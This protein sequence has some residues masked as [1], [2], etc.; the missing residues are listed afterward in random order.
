[1]R[2]K[3]QKQIE[4]KRSSFSLL[5]AIALSMAMLATSLQGNTG[6]ANN[7][8]AKTLWFPA[9]FFFINNIKSTNRIFRDI[10]DTSKEISIQTALFLGHK[11]MVPMASRYLQG[12]PLDDEVKTRVLDAMERDSFR[13]NVVPFLYQIATLY[14]PDQVANIYPPAQKRLVGTFDEAIRQHYYSPNS[15]SG[16]IPG[17]EHELFQFIPQQSEVEAKAEGEAESDQGLPSLDMMASNIITLYDA[18]YLQGDQGNTKEGAPEITPQMIER[19]QKVIAD[20]LQMLS[21]TL[22]SNPHLKAGIEDIVNNHHRMETFIIALVDFLTGTI[23]Q[24]YQTYLEGASR[25]LAMEQQATKLFEQAANKEE[26]LEQI[27]NFTHWILQK[28]KYAVH[29]VIDGLQG[30]LVE[31][32]ASPT[33]WENPFL[34]QIAR[35]DREKERYRPMQEQ[36]EDIALPVDNSFLHHLVTERERPEHYLPWLQQLYRKHKNSIARNGISTTPTVSVRNIPIALT[37]TAVANP[38]GGGTGLPSFHYVDRKQEDGMGER[39]FYFYGNDAIYLPRIAAAHGAKTPH[40][41]MNQLGLFSLNCN[42]NYSEGAIASVD[43]LVNLYA[44]EEARDFGEVIC[45]AELKKRAAVQARIDRLA[46]SLQRDIERIR[47]SFWPWASFQLARYVLKS[48]MKKIAELYYQGLPDYLVYYNPWPDHFAHYYGPFGNAIIS[49]T[50]ELARMDY[51]LQQMEGAYR[52]SGHYRRTLFAMAGDHG[53]AE[54]YYT[55]N[56]ELTVLK[57]SGYDFK[58]IKISSDEGEAPKMHHP[59]NPPTMRDYDVVVAS[60]AGG[61]YMMDFFH[62]DSDGWQEQPTIKD[63]RQHQLL[64]GEQVDI[65]GLTLDQ[66]PETL[67]YLVVRNGPCSPSSTDIMAMAPNGKSAHI[68]RKGERIYYHSKEDLL[69]VRTPSRYAHP[70]G[71]SQRMHYEQ[72]QRQCMDQANPQ[73]SQTWCHETQWRELASYTNNPDSV[74]QLAHLYD[75]PKAGTI[76][77]FPGH[78]IGYNTKVP[79]RHAGEH[80]HEKDSFIGI[81]GGPLENPGPPAGPNP[82]STQRL[83]TAVV[84]QVLPTLYQYIT[85]IKMEKGHDGL[86]FDPIDLDTPNREREVG[87]TTPQ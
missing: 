70:L 41:R 38:E 63:L 84:G 83:Q 31:A 43:G 64:S 74:G 61:N 72:L 87:T 1:M 60:T 16:D 24:Q 29:I 62:H 78:G 82:T 8:K 23:N 76:N 73:D 12:L 6:E 79:G 19:V 48:D 11:I 20:T 75:S 56:P 28:R 85:G 52:D 13:H 15:P 81:W 18:I 46:R 55:L 27:G 66:L 45:I 36:V 37:G 5:A 7:P 65:I 33:P 67:K 68:L 53:L 59:Y 86:S 26:V 22:E 9:P 40:K 58:T 57:Q 71:H 3:K 49:P 34:Q 2:E 54:V 51:W 32:L 30:H 69:E 21:P 50:G 80:F 42:M 77:L 25:R 44:G 4:T 47:N 14:M 35:E 10:Y 39:A 17:L